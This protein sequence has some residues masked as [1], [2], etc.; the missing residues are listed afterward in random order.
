MNLI[1]KCT[2]VSSGKFVILQHGDSPMRIE[3]LECA[4]ATLDALKVG[5]E[6]VVTIAPRVMQPEALE[7]PPAAALDEPVSPDQ[8]VVPDQPLQPAESDT[9]IIES[10]PLVIPAS[11]LADAAASFAEPF[12]LPPDEKAA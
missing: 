3:L 6:Y 4:D 10:G 11:E 9:V 2:F 1:C 5:D 8:P 12:P 7:L